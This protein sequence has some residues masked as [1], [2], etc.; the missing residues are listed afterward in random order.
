MVVRRRLGEGLVVGLAAAVLAGTAWWAS[1]FFTERLI[2]YA[3]IVVGIVVGQGVLI[4]ARKGGAVPAVVA[5]LL[6]LA[7]LLVAQYFIERSLAIANFGADIP[8]WLGF[9]TAREI[10]TDS[11]DGDPLIGLFWLVSAFAAI[12]SA[13]APSRRPVV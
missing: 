7:A 10:V 8:L 6:T 3:A 11:V 13:G 9:G 2:V 5:G 12:I 4:G 1:V